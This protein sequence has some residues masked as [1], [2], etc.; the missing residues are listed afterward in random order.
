MELSEKSQGVNFNLIKLNKMKT[1]VKNLLSPRTY[2][3]VANQYEINTPK[4]IF[5][6]SYQS[7]IAKQCKVSRKIYLD[8]Y[9]WD[10]SRTTLKYLKQF[11]NIDKSKRDMEKDIKEGKYI[12]TDLNK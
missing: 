6:Q 2:N 1:R 8:S 5:F 9:Y 3:P 10:Y 12:L 4:E 11:L 7:I